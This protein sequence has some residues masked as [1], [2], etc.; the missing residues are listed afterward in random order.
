MKATFKY[1][2]LE[3][4]EK[5]LTLW[6]NRPEK[7]NAFNTEFIAELVRCLLEIEKDNSIRFLVLRG[8]GSMF[9][10]GADLDW[11]LKSSELTFEDNFNESRELAEVFSSLYHLPIPTL[12]VTHGKVFGG[13]L[14]LTAAADFAWT[15]TDTNFCFSEVKVGLSP[16]TIIPYIVNKT[17]MANTKEL[18]YSAAVFDDNKANEIG[19]ID[20]I[21]SPNELEQKLEVFVSS[22]IANA[23]G[24]I[25]ESKKMIQL[26]NPVFID[27]KMIV[28]TAASIAKRRTTSEAREGINA[29]FEKRKPNWKIS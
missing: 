26:V 10:A 29:F 15:V 3:R 6:L 12:V 1:I 23:G 22:I 25:A 2:L 14:G 8:K 7:R 18:V 19:L 4:T 21:V 11:M 17:G 24:A 9:S 28:N 13:A 20:K 27:E 16:S 5:V